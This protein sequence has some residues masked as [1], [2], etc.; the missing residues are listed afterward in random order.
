MRSFTTISLVIAAFLVLLASVSLFFLQRM[1]EGQQRTLELYAVAVEEAAEAERLRS[2]SEHIGRLVRTY[3]LIPNPQTQED[4]RVSRERFDAVTARMLTNADSEG[5]RA[6]VLQV[7][8]AEQQARNTSESLGR[9]RARG[10]RVG[11]IQQL[12]LEQYQP[13]REALDQAIEALVR[14]QQEELRLNQQLFLDETRRAT[15]AF[16]LDFLITLVS[17]LAFTG[18]VVREV[19]NRTIAQEKAEQNAAELEAILGS[20]PDTVLVGDEHRLQRLNTLGM[21]RMGLE[22]A[23]ELGDV[24]ELFRKL[25]MRDVRTGEELKLEELPYF[26]ALQGRCTTREVVMRSPLTGEELI[27]RT[28]AAPVRMRGKVISAIDISVDISAQKRL[29]EEQRFLLQAGELLA[30]SLDYEQ[31]LSAVARLAV[32]SLA[33]WCIINLVEEGQVRRHEVAHREPERGALAAALEQVWLR[34]GQPFLAQEV[35]EKREPLLVEHITPEYLESLA[36]GEEQS[37][38][39]RQLA[40]CSLLAVPLLSGQR[41]LGV[42]VFLSDEPGHTFDSGDLGVAQS[43]ARI[44]CLAMENARLYRSAQRA[45]RARDEVLGIVAHDLRSPL[46]IISLNIQLLERKVAEGAVPGEAMLRAISLAVQRMDRL[47]QDLLDVARLEGGTLAVS[48]SPRSGTSLLEEAFESARPLAEEVRLSLHKSEALPAVWADRERVLQVFSNLLGNALK[49]TPPG[50]EVSLGARVEG[51][52]VCFFVHD[53]GPGIPREALE[54]LFERLWLAHRGDRRGAGLG[55]YIAKG[56]VEAHGGRIWVE[57][58]PGR[59][60]TFFFTLP[61]ASE[62][63]AH[64]G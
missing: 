32:Q 53:T 5:E 12:L 14:Q 44:A 61:I 60:S 4:L 15:R 38:L 16:Q 10:A 20:F 25:R 55:L 37:R 54:H 2:E 64:G 13:E 45:T 42:I 9:L 1:T 29:E 39:L 8:R 19:R 27:V 17:L 18:L 30:S 57:S 36:K 58:E 28:T 49:F 43:L 6:L 24:R 21:E 62:L 48:P 40:P 22:R 63:A 50:G 52:A 26:Q 41:L 33:S 35:L 31:T 47:I 59:G 56:L 3:L 34:S 11:E 46:N 7:D 51:T 23:Q